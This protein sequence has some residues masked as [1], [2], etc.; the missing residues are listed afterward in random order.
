MLMV[1]A[2]SVA[3]FSGVASSEWMISIAQSPEEKC[4]AADIAAVLEER[5]PMADRSSADINLRITMLR[6]M[7][8]RTNAGRWNRILNIASQYL[9]IAKASAVDNNAPDPFITGRLIDHAFALH[10][11]TNHLNSLLLN[12]RAGKRA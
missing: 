7:R 6:S 5:D 9:R 3:Q 11:I 1:R 8:D 10:G 4:L 2:T 12:A